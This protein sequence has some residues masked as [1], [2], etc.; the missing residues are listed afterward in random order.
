MKEEPWRTSFWNKEFSWEMGKFL[1]SPQLQRELDFIFPACRVFLNAVLV[2]TRKC[3]QL[4]WE[5]LLEV[6]DV[7][8][9][10]LRCSPHRY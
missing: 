8:A 1:N 6:L 7:I 3:F 4:T 9:V 10:W 2:V 5:H